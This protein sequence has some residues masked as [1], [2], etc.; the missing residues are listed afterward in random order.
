MLQGKNLDKDHSW[1][2]YQ[3]LISSFKLAIKQ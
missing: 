2:R 3:A 1:M